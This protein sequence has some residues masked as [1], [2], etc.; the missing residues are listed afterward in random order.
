MNSI[1]KHITE[2][3][4]EQYLNNYKKYN[5]FQQKSQIQRMIVLEV[6]TDP[7]LLTDEDYATLEYKLSITNPQLLR[8]APRD[9]IIA[10]TL[11]NVGLT[12]IQQSTIL[13]PAISHMR[14]PIRAGE[15]VL[16]LFEDPE[17]VNSIGYWLSRLPSVKFVDDPNIM[18]HPREH[19]P[20]FKVN[21]TKQNQ[22]QNYAFNNGVTNSDG[23]VIGETETLYGGQDAYVN[24]ITGSICGS[25]RTIEPVPRFKRRIDDTSI[26][27]ARGGL[28]VLG[29]HREAS[30]YTKDTSG[31]KKTEEDKPASAAI[32][33]TVGRGRTSNT[34]VFVVENDIG[35]TEAAKDYNN[36]NPTEGNP[37]FI[38]DAARTYIAQNAKIDDAFKLEKSV[39][40]LE[41][42]DASSITHKADDLR[43][44]SRRNIRLASIENKKLDNGTL[45]DADNATIKA[46]FALDASGNIGLKSSN[47]YTI[48]IDNNFETTSK[49]TK[50]K[51]SDSIDLDA[52]KISIGGTK[53]PAPLF[54]AFCNSLADLFSDLIITINAGTVGTAAKQQFVEIVKITTSLNNMIVNLKLA[55]KA[56]GD[57][58][59]KK[60][61][62]G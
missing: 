14:M 53:H 4:S 35:T 28:L 25:L 24:V 7:E 23:I 10:T 8:V 22:K 13:F 5:H 58:A 34:G 20:T 56:Q 45:T 59:S 47:D 9:T 50:L 37:D 46:E 11:I 43:L 31:L 61:T 62:N 52:D 16:A 3:T 44:I 21:L 36:I 33:I 30:A 17:D 2:G 26:E 27:S 29:S 49:T 6:I 1:D 18:H 39:L 41:S 42:T 55:A 60:V 54:D 57:F 48:K 32:D 19:D 12:S 38:N 15:H 51:S 40:D